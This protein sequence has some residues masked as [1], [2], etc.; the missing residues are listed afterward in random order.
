QREVGPAIALTEGQCRDGRGGPDGR[1][2]AAAELPPE[3]VR[4]E[5]VEDHNAADAAGRE[6]SERAGRGADPVDEV[7]DAND[8]VLAED[9]QRAQRERRQPPPASPGHR[10]AYGGRPGRPP[11]RPHVAYLGS[12]LH[13]APPP[14]HP[15]P[16]PPLEHRPSP[17]PTA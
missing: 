7:V 6:R 12:P 10:E 1:G 2:P 9:D 14:I 8:G 13:H 4:D 15:L 3:Q 16:H 17:T 11:R 5:P